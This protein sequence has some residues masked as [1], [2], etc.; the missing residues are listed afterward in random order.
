MF[1]NFFMRGVPT[2]SLPWDSRAVFG[3]TLNLCPPNPDLHNNFN[4]INRYC[5]IAIFV[6]QR[7][8]FLQLSHNVLWKRRRLKYNLTD[9]IS[10]IL[11]IW[12]PFTLKARILGPICSDRSLEATEWAQGTGFGPSFYDF[13]PQIASDQV[14]VGLTGTDPW[15]WFLTFRS[16]I[17]F[18]PDSITIALKW[19]FPCLWQVSR[20]IKL[21]LW[22]N[23]VGISKW[24]WILS[25]Y[26]IMIKLWDYKYNDY[27]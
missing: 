16:P 13:G 25:E 12:G 5:S 17:F 6:K 26:N 23:P 2:K 3:R 20:C 1:F 14:V 21:K 7:K 10:F 9:I 8:G 18:S 4:F 24:I 11:G 27:D 15:L 19:Y 22:G